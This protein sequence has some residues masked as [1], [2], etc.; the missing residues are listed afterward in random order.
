MSSTKIKEIKKERLC[1]NAYKEVSWFVKKNIF[2]GQHLYKVEKKQKVR[3]NDSNSVGENLKI[4][5]V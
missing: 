4:Q 2:S 3:V 5:W 1:L